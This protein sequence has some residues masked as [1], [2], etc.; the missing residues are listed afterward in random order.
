MYGVLADVLL[1]LVMLFALPDSPHTLIQK[2]EYA[3]YTLPQPPMHT[4]VELAYIYVYVHKVTGERVYGGLARTRGD[5]TS[6]L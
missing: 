1:G 3:E 4:G 2:V 5:S 6:Q